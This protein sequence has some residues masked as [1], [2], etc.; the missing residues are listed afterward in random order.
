MINRTSKTSTRP[1][2]NSL[3]QKRGGMQY[4]QDLLTYWTKWSNDIKWSVD[5]RW[6]FWSGA[7]FTLSMPP[8]TTSRC[9]MAT[10]PSVDLFSHATNRCPW[11]QIH[12]LWL[13]D[14]AAFLGPFSN[15]CCPV[16]LLADWCCWDGKCHEKFRLSFMT[17]SQS[18]TRV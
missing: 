10:V 14:S 13:Q 9:H 3:D 5:L 6:L 15:M 4:H 12:P 16:M 8:A 7:T 2:M 1:P 11:P 17:A 18:S